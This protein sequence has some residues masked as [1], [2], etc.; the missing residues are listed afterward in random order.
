MTSSASTPAVEPPRGFIVCSTV[1]RGVVLLM[2][3]VT[4]GLDTIR[5][6]YWSLGLGALFGLGYECFRKRPAISRPRS[7]GEKLWRMAVGLVFIVVLIFRIPDNWEPLHTI[8]H[9]IEQPAFL[10]A[11]WFIFLAAVLLFRKTLN[12]IRPPSVT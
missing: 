3:Y 1:S 2:I 4:M 8:V 7:L 6:G 11:L 12:R 9:F 10:T 5:D